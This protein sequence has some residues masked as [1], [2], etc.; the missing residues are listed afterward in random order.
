M[1][2]I[3]FITT[4]LFLLPFSSLLNPADLIGNNSIGSIE[5][6]RFADI[7]AVKGNLLADIAALEQVV[8]GMKDGKVYQ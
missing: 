2:T 6:G 3:P 5:A 7:I 1:K 8:F 4:L